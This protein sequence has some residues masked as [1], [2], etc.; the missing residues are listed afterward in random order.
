MLTL[1]ALS[2]GTAYATQR[3]SYG[4]PGGADYSAIADVIKSNSQPHDCVVFGF[5][6]HEPLRAAA[7]ARPDAF[8]QLDDVAAGVSGAYAAQLWTQDL[9][10]DSDT[11]RPRLASCT[12][13]WAIIDRETPTPVVEAAQR[14]GL[15][16]DRQWQLNRS[17]VVRLKRPS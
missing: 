8:A 2:S 6:Q 9:P 17:R 12:V 5:A 14:Q 13:L 1:L 4:K 16:I 10:V 15:T 11:V 3:S 7:A